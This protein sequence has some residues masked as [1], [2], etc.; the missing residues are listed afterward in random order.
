L[1]GE[2]YTPANDS[3]VRGAMAVHGFTCIIVE[4][5]YWALRADLIIYL[6]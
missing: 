5:G 2:C 1:V 4:T 3:G 6:C